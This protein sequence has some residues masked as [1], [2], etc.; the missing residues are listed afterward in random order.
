MDFKTIV[1]DNLLIICDND[2]KK[3]MLS[4]LNA[5]KNIYDIKFMNINEVVKKL[6]FDYDK[7]SIYYLMNKYNLTYEIAKIYIDNMYY[8]DDKEYK[9]DKL[10]ML[11]KYKKEL[12]ENNLLIKDPLFIDYIKNKKIKV[13][14]RK[15]SKYN[16]YV[17]NILRNYTSVEIYDFKYDNYK[18][19]VYEFDYL[20][21]EIE[22]VAYSICELIDSGV[23]INKIKISNIDE[24]YINPIKRIFKSYNIPINIPNDSY[25]IG[26]KIGKDF[27]NN[28]RPNINDTIDLLDKENPIFNKII[29]ICNKY[30]FIDDY[31]KVK[32]MLVY[33]LS[34][35]K[36]PSIKYDNAIEIVD[37]KDLFDD[38]YVF[39]MN[40]NLKSIPNIYKDEDFLTDSIKP[41]Y[42]DTTI[43]KN[44]L[45]KDITIKSINNIKNLII[46]YK[47]MTPTSECY[48]SNLTEG[49]II[50]RPNINI[51]KSYS[52]ENDELKLASF[53]DKLIKYGYKD[54]E[55]NALKFN[56]DIDYM[57][58]DNK[59]QKVDKNNLYAMM[60]NK[61][62]LSYSKIEE[63][64]ECPFRYYL[65]KVLNL[66]IYEENFGATL[67]TIFHHILEIGINKEID[68]DK[69]VEIFINSEYKDKK[70]T[71]MEKFFLENAKENMRFSLDTIK[72]Q[73]KY[74]KLNKVLTE[75]KVYIS[76]DKNLKITFSGIIDKVLY[77]EEN[78]T[79][80]AIIDYKTGNSV[81]I[82]LGYMEY[83][84]GLQLPIYLYLADNM[85]LENIKFAGIYL[86]KIMPDIEKK[87]EAK[88]DKLKLEGYS[89]S[90]V[91]I[92]EKFDSTFEDSEV[93][94]G[95]KTKQDGSFYAT[96]KVLSDKEFEALKKLAEKQID[97]SI[98]NI[99]D[100]KFDI[101]PIKKETDQE[102]TA[103]KFC[104]YKDIC[105]R[106]NND[107]R[108][109]KKDKELSFLGG[110]INA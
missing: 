62:S 30:T 36:I 102:I 101:S 87:E 59:Y 79:I 50:E 46:T 12:E 56:Y 86:Q 92:I 27:I 67:G 21:K 24:E 109:L 63:Y 78:P 52:K 105:F 85:N 2:I 66:D 100:A 74:C 38:E 54:D 37:Y 10:N 60:N 35:T 22:Y 58:Y 104:K 75:K 81:D 91:E 48:P 97:A 47:K 9:N 82:D 8:I 26:T 17:F 84:I 88:E 44:K 99:L 43:E 15:I 41:T 31:T 13:C 57:K 72:K 96:S 110:D 90:N 33:D 80:V 61:L 107:I 53:L 83:G 14:M 95:L 68:I 19:K 55:L 18:H 77:N 23:D 5:E 93:I 89:N 32:D 71:N 11:V 94:K 49:L 73:M 34:N 45:E 29:N 98:E 39:L 3:K 70:F 7:E 51:Y 76:K 20:D 28:I 25:I 106:T 103:C 6:Y 65:S 42:L 108:N 4:F 1:E 16:N 69:E 40:F 64:N